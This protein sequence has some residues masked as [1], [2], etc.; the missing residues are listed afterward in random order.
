MD[1]SLAATRQ[2]VTSYFQGYPRLRR[3]LLVFAAYLL[4]TA[5]LFT[6]IDYGNREGGDSWGHYYFATNGQLSYHTNRP[7]ALLPVALFAYSFGL[8]PIFSHTLVLLG[9]CLNGYLLFLI[10]R[11]YI[12]S[13]WWVGYV[14]G[15]V[16][17]LFFVPD[18]FFLL[19]F[20]AV[21]DNLFSLTF[22][23]LALYLYV[24][25]SN[26]G[27]YY[28]LIIASMLA[29]IASGMREALLPLLVSVPVLDFLL[30]RQY[31]WT[32]FVRLCIWSGFIL[33]PVVWYALPILGLE[34][35]TYSS[36]FREPL[37]FRRILSRISVQLSATIQ[38]FFLLQVNKLNVYRLP[39]LLV[40]VGLILGWLLLESQGQRQTVRQVQPAHQ[41]VLLPI[42]W[43]G[44]GTIIWLLGL[45]AYLLTIV[46]DEVIRVHSA[47]PLGIGILIAS[48]A[49]LLSE[50]VPK[51]WPRNIIVILVLSF[52]GTISVIQV[53]D[54]QNELYVLDSVWSD[55]AEYFRT[56]THIA[57]DVDDETLI[58]HVQPRGQDD[59][60]FIY[61]FGFQYSIQATYGEAVRS[62]VSNDRLTGSDWQISEDGI[63]ITQTHPGPPSFAFTNQHYN[64]E[65]VIFVTKDKTG[66]SVILQS[67]SADSLAAF[68]EFND[69]VD[70]SVIGPDAEAAYAPYERIQRGYVDE[71]V[72]AVYPP[73]QHLD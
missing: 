27:S 5:A 55:Q 68:G 32:A 35:E 20:F 47:T 25:S 53:S 23:L 67:I 52:V 19:N 39:I 63:T 17:I 72:Q 51:T 57:P 60:P 18:W 2:A 1:V 24:L 42:V 10:L 73:L 64:W 48:G 6:I 31:N 69:Y 46:A 49:W 66:R 36:G 26:N 4:V 38:P 7:T 34:G 37:S 45:F 41:R 3:D 13:K 21:S 11:Q 58:V 30:R 12:P 14:A 44:L 29:L 43:L 71:Q 15:L 70:L 50:I 61:G 9:R 22:M 40:N 56:L 59:S 8:S 28:M 33:M 16:Y 54:L 62:L 65:Q